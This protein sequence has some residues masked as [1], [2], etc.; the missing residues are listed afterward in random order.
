MQS[1][2][3]FVFFIIL[4]LLPKFLWRSTSESC[5]LIVC[6]QKLRTNESTSGR[7]KIKHHQLHLS[8]DHVFHRSISFS[9]WAGS[10]LFC[11][12]YCTCAVIRSWQTQRRTQF[13]GFLLEVLDVSV[14][15][16]VIFHRNHSMHA[17]F[18]VVQLWEIFCQNIRIH[19][20]RP[21]FFAEVYVIFAGC[22]IHRLPPVWAD[23]PNNPLCL[24]QVV[25]HS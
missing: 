23:I 16:Q 2:N 11:C 17:T 21:V 19:F 3:F 24:T 13:C 5:T 4:R 14:L 8:S 10:H 12:G 20:R 25:F 22:D 9:R 18:Q 6:V 7:Q 1:P 15:F